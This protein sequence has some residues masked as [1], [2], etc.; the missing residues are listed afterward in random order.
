MNLTMIV[1]FESI[2]Y[3]EEF[4]LQLA[5]AKLTTNTCHDQLDR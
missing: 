3:V 1:S 2:Q 5:L 4:P